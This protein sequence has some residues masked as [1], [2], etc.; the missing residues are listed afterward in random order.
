MEN[1]AIHPAVFAIKATTLQV[2]MAYSV[3]KHPV[4]GQLPIMA[5]LLSTILLIYKTC[6][7]QLQAG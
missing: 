6:Y 7:I 5:Q 3:P 1:N 2:S 4:T